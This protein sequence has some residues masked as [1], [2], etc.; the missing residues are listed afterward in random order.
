MNP[1][2]AVARTNAEGA[3]EEISRS[4]IAD[5]R[6][7]SREAFSKLYD[8]HAPLLFALAVRMLGRRAEAEDA[9]QDAMLQAWKTA[10][11]YDPARGGVRSWLVVILRSRCL[12]GLRRR[13]T[14]PFIAEADALESAE[15]P[16]D[17]RA[18]LAE[19]EDAEDR[20]AVLSALDALPPAQRAVLESS[21]FD[22]LSQTEIAAKT[23]DPLGT[24]KTRMRLGTMRLLELLKDRMRA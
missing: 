21:Y 12:D 10:G 6:R 17:E 22:G 20:L 4:L 7:G 18:T 2:D 15:R 23:G 13:S 8:L 24:V 1:E 14:A 5:A 9:L 16:S 11:T 3:A 19:L